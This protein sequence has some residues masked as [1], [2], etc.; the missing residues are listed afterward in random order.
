MSKKS[1]RN[2]TEQVT[3]EFLAA[4]RLY[5]SMCKS[6]LSHTPEAATA[7]QRMY[8]AAPESFRQEMHDMAV[9]MGLMPAVRM[10]IP[11]TES[12][13]TNW[14]GWPSGWALIPKR[15]SA[16]TKSWASSRT[17]SKSIG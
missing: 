5:T 7:F 10:A 1:K 13:F 15:R 3:P 2:T 14:K 12:P 16:K 9:Q 8:D 17:P 11:T 4:G 6:G